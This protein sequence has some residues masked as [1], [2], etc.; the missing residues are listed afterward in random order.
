MQRSFIET[1]LEKLEM[2]DSTVRRSS[3]IV[4]LYLS[5]GTDENTEVSSRLRSASKTNILLKNCGTYPLLVHSLCSSAE[6]CKQFAGNPE[7]PTTSPSGIKADFDMRLYLNLLYFLLE[8]NKKDK[9]FI[10]EISEPCVNDKSLVFILFNLVHDFGEPNGKLYPIKKLLLML[11]KTLHFTLGSLNVVAERKEK[12]RKELGLRSYPNGF[13]KARKEHLQY[14]QNEVCARFPYTDNN[15]SA[16]PKPIFEGLH[17]IKNH[18]YISVNDIQREVEDEMLANKIGSKH[19][20]HPFNKKGPR[21]L[22]ADTPL[23]EV[24]YKSLLPDFSRYIII[25]LKILLAASPSVKNYTG[26]INLMCEIG[27]QKTEGYVAS[28]QTNMDVSRHKEIVIKAISSILL[29]LLKHLK[30]NHIYQFEFVCQL[31]VDANCLL[32]I[33]KFLNQQ[34]LAAFLTAKNDISDLEFFF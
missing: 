18:L 15:P 21:F 32:L 8:F 30:L 14:F 10:T 17:V 34:D 22:H 26:A 2:T 19:A 6:K 29:I 12:I 1:C 23:I 33:L 24:L 31:L 3:G 25:I 16:L 4:L 28:V 20:K 9:D 7:D 11:W 13:T 27:E 5:A